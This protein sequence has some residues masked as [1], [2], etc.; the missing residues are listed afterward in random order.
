M[1]TTAARQFVD[2]PLQRQQ[3]LEAYRETG[4][5]VLSDVF[6]RTELGRMRS[7]WAEISEQRR[8]EGKKAHAT[9]LMMHAL[10]PGVAQIVRSPLLV[11]CVEGFLGGKIELIQSQLMYGM[12]GAKG[13][14]PHQD[15]FYNRAD[16]KDGIVAAW[17]A[18]EDVDRENG[19]LAVFPVS[20]KNGLAETRK[21]WM[22]LLTR[23]PDVLK[24]LMRATSPAR[25]AQ[26]DDSSVIERFVYAQAPKDIE[27]V[28]L[29][30]KAGSVAFMHGDAIH[31]S[32]PNVTTDRSR[33]SLLTNYVKVGT[34]F[35]A[36][37]LSGRVPFDVYASG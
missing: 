18:L 29:A 28:A 7:T 9:L 17:I 33:R 34:A 27:P 1:Q 13:F 36:G 10:D 35:S 12:P 15:N 8:K 31:F 16:P 23:S 3:V 32:Y 25:R 22:Y 6:D 19:S 20:H 21:D 14:S 4:F 24:S 2:D 37:K 5:V 26:P 30:M 11:K